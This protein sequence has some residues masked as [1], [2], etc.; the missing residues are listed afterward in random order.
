MTSEIYEA[1]IE[2]VVKGDVTQA[3]DLANQ[4]LAQGIDP[5]ALL[6]RDSQKEKSKVA[7]IQTRTFKRRA[8]DSQEIGRLLITPA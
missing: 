6:K 4:G 5:L 2:S 1:A 8:L 7:K 3:V